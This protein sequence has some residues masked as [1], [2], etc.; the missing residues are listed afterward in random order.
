MKKGLFTFGF[1]LVVLISSA[2]SFKKGDVV[3]S[4]GLG[5]SAFDF[6]FLNSYMKYLG[7]KQ[8]YQGPFTGKLELALSDVV[9]IGV[10]CGFSQAY[11]SWSRIDS[12]STTIPTEYKY[13][14]DYIKSTIT[15]RLNVHFVRHQYFDAYFGLGI[16][17]KTGHYKTTTN[18]PFFSNN[19]NLKTLPV[20]FEC[21]LGVRGYFNPT[22]GAFLEAGAGH[23][24]IQ[25]GVIAKLPGRKK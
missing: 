9:G 7:F 4:G 23:G 1:L 18:D 25:G 8:S 13:R 2:Q 15:P 24:Y 19:I 12:V 22:W 11:A 10:S 3:V 16:G 21:S 20:S 17:A 14:F 6:S 5:K